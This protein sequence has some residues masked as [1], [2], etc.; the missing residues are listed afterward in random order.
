APQLADRNQSPPRGRWQS[1]PRAPIP[2]PTQ[3]AT[4]PPP[5]RHRHNQTTSRPIAACLDP[6]RSWADSDWPA[7]V[8]AAVR[9]PSKMPGRT[10]LASAL[11][12][13]DVLHRFA[14][15]R[16]IAAYGAANQMALRQTVPTTAWPPSRR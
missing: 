2:V 9:P 14:A 12:G 10:V 3:I 16:A 15:P 7:N 8:S 4:T 5:I 6:T 1:M 13:A 11:G